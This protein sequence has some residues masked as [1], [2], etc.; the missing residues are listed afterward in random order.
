MNPLSQSHNGK[1]NMLV[2]TAY[3]NQERDKIFLNLASFL[4]TVQHVPV[5]VLCGI[6]AGVLALRPPSVENKRVVASCQE[7]EMR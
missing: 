6:T 3:L 4:A 7:L 1:M 2:L 5:E